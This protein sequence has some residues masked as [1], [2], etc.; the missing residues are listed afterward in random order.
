[1]RRLKCGEERPQCFRCKKSGWRCDGYDHGTSSNSTPLPRTP[2]PK[3]SVYTSPGTLNL[4]EGE[5]RYFRAFIDQ[6]PTDIDSRDTESPFWKQTVLQE[7]H[8][9]PCVLHTIVAQGALAMSQVGQ[10]PWAYLFKFDNSQNTHHE[11]AL[12]QYEKALRVLRTSIGGLQKG[13]GARSTLISA[14]ALSRFDC[15]CGNGGFATQHVRFARRLLASWRLA[16]N[17]SSGNTIASEDVIDDKLI[18]M[19]QRLDVSLLCLM[20]TDK[21]VNYE[22]IQAPVLPMTMMSNQFLNFEEARQARE[23]LLSSGYQFILHTL[24]YQFVPQEEIPAS[25]HALRK[26]WLDQIQLWNNALDPVLRNYATDATMHPFARPEFCRLQTIVMSLWITGTLYTPETAYD[27]L[28][29]HFEYIVSVAE[30]L[31]EFEKTNTESGY[32]QFENIE[33]FTPSP[34]VLP[35]LFLC[36][37]KCRHNVLRGRA[38]TLLLS[39]HRRE[40]IWDSL[41]CGKVADWLFRLEE[42][43]GLDWDGQGKAPRKWDGFVDGDRRVWG[44]SVERDLHGSGRRAV[45]RCRQNVP[46]ERGGGWVERETVVEW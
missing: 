42:D 46:A 3:I 15:F 16:N 41:L 21:E 8:S 26:H 12:T 14:L 39:S 2:S 27:G 6:K 24:Q 45:V 19:F 25:L 30:E 34:L 17:A 23:L 22:N 18:R 38:I 43:A 40:G 33:T 37:A 35:G 28:M 11:F 1:M 5:R 29:Q 32:A 13:K 20:G 31:I 9:N 36:A 7:C 44:A 4:T 10:T